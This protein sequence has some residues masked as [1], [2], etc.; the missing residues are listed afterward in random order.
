MA[1]MLSFRAAYG[2]TEAAQA[3][4]AKRR[5]NKSG[6]GRDCP[7]DPPRNAVRQEGGI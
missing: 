4:L 5:R 6:R 1:D 7:P 3:P 2:V